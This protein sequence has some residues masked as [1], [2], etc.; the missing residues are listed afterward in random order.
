MALSIVPM[1][2]AMAGPCAKIAGTAP[3]PWRQEDFERAVKDEN[4]RCFAALHN[5]AVAGFACF[6]ALCG[7]ADLQLVAV[8]PGCRR[9]G[10]AKALLRYAIVQLRDEGVKRVLLE[11]RASNSGAIVL[12]RGLGFVHLASRPGMYARPKEDGVLMGLSLADK[13]ETKE[14]AP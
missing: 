2:P 3:D 10:V 1:T 11:A 4:R 9:Q 8:A 6:L 5:G 14:A 13:T 7:S 12:Y